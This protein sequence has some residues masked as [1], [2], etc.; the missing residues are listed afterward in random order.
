MKTRAILAAA[1]LIIGSA[2]LY[3]QVVTFG[4][5]DTNGILTATVPSNSVYSVEWSWVR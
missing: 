1:A 5:L 3:A 2:T 4:S